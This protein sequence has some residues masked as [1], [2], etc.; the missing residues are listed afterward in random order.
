LF[1]FL[2]YF[3]FNACSFF[4]SVSIF[5]TFNLCLFLFCIYVLMFARYYLHYSILC[6]RKHTV[7]WILS[8]V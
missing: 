1:L 5:A 2:I 6:L 3:S 8:S 4:T 7:N